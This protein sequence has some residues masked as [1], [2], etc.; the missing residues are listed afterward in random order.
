MLT[1]KTRVLAFIKILARIFPTTLEVRSFL[2]QYYRLLLLD[3]NALLPDSVY[4]LKNCCVSV[5]QQEVAA[6]RVKRSY[7]AAFLPPTLYNDVVMSKR[8]L[9]TVAAVLPAECLDAQNV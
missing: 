2:L 3:P 9:L 7:A 6:G 5:L 1:H 8:E 4:Q